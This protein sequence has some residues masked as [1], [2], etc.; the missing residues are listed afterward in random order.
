MVQESGCVFPRFHWVPPLGGALIHTPVMLICLW[1]GIIS[2][3]YLRPAHSTFLHQFVSWSTLILGLL[4]ILWFLLFMLTYP[5]LLVFLVASWI[6]HTLHS[7]FFSL[8]WMLVI[9]GNANRWFII[10]GSPFLTCL[11]SCHWIPLYWT[12]QVGFWTH[13]HLSGHS[14]TQYCFFLGTLHLLAK[15]P[16]SSSMPHTIPD[17]RSSSTRHPQ[18]LCVLFSLVFSK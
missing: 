17:P 10:T 3:Q 15:D 8:T 18:F 16:C 6:H 2:Q 13:S 1:S 4:C 14:H 11:P 9:S 5:V 12:I 7:H